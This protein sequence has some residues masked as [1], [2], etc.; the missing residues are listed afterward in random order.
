M[1]VRSP[2]A[3]MVALAW[4]GLRAPAMIAGSRNQRNGI[5][6]L[7]FSTLLEVKPEQES[8]I[9]QNIKLAHGHPV[10]VAGQ[11]VWS[12]TAISALCY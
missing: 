12:Q 7:K 9:I 5:G 10:P 3:G 2:P 4:G 8:T 1:L 6:K 11:H